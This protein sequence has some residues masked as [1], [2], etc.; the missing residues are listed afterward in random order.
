MQ[1]LWVKIPYLS[2]FFSTI[3][4]SRALWDTILGVI[5]TTTSFLLFKVD[6]LTG[7]LFVDFLI[8]IQHNYAITALITANDNLGDNTGSSGID[9]DGIVIKGIIN[10][11]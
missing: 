10:L 8:V 9:I 2:I 1:K 6:Q 5:N 4:S 11:H 7:D 3:L